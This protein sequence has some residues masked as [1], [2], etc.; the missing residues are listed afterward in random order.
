M[1]KGIGPGWKGWGLTA[2]WGFRNS[3]PLKDLKAIAGRGQLSRW[4]KG[5]FSQGLCLNEL[6]LFGQDEEFLGKARDLPDT[7]NPSRHGRLDLKDTDG[8]PTNRGLPENWTLRRLPRP[9]LLDRVP[10]PA[11]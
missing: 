9:I 4:C 7:S 8:Q 3:G 11:N 2:G 6:R 10:L 5:A 1:V